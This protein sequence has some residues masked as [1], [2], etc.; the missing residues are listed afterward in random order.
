MITFNHHSKF[1]KSVIFEGTTFR[2]KNFSCYAEKHY[3]GADVVLLDEK[4]VI[5][6]FHKKMYFCV[7]TFVQF[8]HIQVAVKAI[9]TFSHEIAIF[10]NKRFNT[11]E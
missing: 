3:T 10:N 2:P 6:P 5:Q 7:I 1:F 4:T 11:F 9:S 8:A